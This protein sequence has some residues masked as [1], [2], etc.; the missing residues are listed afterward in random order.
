MWF[1]SSLLLP[2]SAGLLCVVKRVY[3]K[4]PDAGPND[5]TIHR[6]CMEICKEDETTE[7]CMTDLCN[8]ATVSASCTS[9]SLC[10]LLI[11]ALFLCIYLLCCCASWCRLF[12]TRNQMYGLNDRHDQRWSL[13]DFKTIHLS[14]SSSYNRIADCDRWMRNR[15]GL[16][17]SCR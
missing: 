2:I 1:T 6:N 14:S 17:T 7:C 5:F 13:C 10:L 3:R 9:K 16:G 8:G 15:I 12:T 4:L 11:V